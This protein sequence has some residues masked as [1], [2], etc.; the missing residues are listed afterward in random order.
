VPKRKPRQ[1]VFDTETSGLR[2][3]P[4]AR[5]FAYC[6]ADEECK[7]DVY[8]LFD[9]PTELQTRAANVL[10]R[11]IYDAEHG[12]AEIIGHNVPFDIEMLERW[13]G[14]PLKRFRVHETMAQA[15]LIRNDRRSFGLDNIAWEVFGFPKDDDDLAA[16]YMS[17]SRGLMDCPAF[18]LDPYQV[19][20]GE[21]TWLIDRRYRPVIKANPE[22]N[23]CYEYD[24]ALTWTQRAMENRGIML[25]HRRAEALIADL[26]TKT[27]DALA[28]Y[29]SLS[30][31]SGTPNSQDVP[32]ILQSLGLPLTKRTKGS[33][34][35]S[36]RKEVL[37]ALRESHPHPILEA[38]LKYR[39][40]QHGKST[41]Q[42]YIDAADSDWTVRTN[43]FPYLET[44][45]R[46]SSKVNLQNVSKEVNP[47]N[48]YPIA[49]RKCFRA[50]PGYI[51]I[52]IDYAGIEARL[53]AHFSGDPELLRIFNEGNGDFHT[54]F[55]ETLYADVWS[56]YDA[57]QRKAWRG[58]AKNGDFGLAYGAGED[59]F[60]NTVGR[61]GE[62]DAYRRVRERFPVYC[63]MSRKFI[64]IVRQQGYIV[65][66]F[67]RHLY[68]P[69]NKPY[70]GTN[71][72]CQGA[73]AEILKRAEVNV[74]KY[75]NEAT[76][77]EVKLI[78]TIHDEI[79]TEVPRKRLKDF[80][81]DCLPRVRQIMTDFPQLTVPLD[82]EV[83]TAPLDWAAAKEYSI[84]QQ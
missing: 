41:I 29:R 17:D 21:R 50:R 82:I 76:G 37:V 4:D 57:K 22:W 84:D 24:C 60:L 30:G 46:S 44:G 35:L 38:V 71:T 31:S 79:I 65:T 43:L 10:R 64:D 59:K 49:A 9:G 20:D 61:P 62:H 18:V 16:K 52:L 53:L 81:G 13:Y 25:D 15:F 48:P 32:K 3:N 40:Y 68:V 27:A 83:K 11:L 67:G 56:T 70:Q 77:G 12:R 23:E 75:Y 73:G 39:A 26:E 28:E 74:D 7:V 2:T 42:G 34:K 8:R 80:M 14:K 5:M 47:S 69:R 6:V 55:A 54:A 19:A 63:G 1:V 66:P 36:T 45:R 58:R 72:A 78:L 33:D 51:N